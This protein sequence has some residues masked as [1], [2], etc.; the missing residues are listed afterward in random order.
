MSDY[1]RDGEEFD[2]K[3]LF[4]KKDEFFST[5]PEYPSDWVAYVHPCMCL[6]ALHLHRWRWVAVLCGWWQRLKGVK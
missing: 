3:P 6:P 2:Y 1:Y 5:V 4:D